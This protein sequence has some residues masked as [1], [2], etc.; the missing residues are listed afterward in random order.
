MM[1]EPKLE[2]LTVDETGTVRLRAA[3]AREK[4]VKITIT[5]DTNSLSALRN[6]SQRTGVPY[7][8]LVSRVLK[9]DLARQTATESRL[10]QLEREVKRILVA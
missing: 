2:D 7:H 5:I 8:A 10:D 6:A 3:V 4:A 9:K 1:R